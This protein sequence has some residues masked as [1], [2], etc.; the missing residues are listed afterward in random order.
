MDMAPTMN[1]IT[2]AYDHQYINIEDGVIQSI[3]EEAM[4]PLM[5]IN[6]DHPSAVPFIA[7][8]DNDCGNSSN[9]GLS[10]IEPHH[11]DPEEAGAII[12]DY[13]EKYQC[14]F[15]TDHPDVVAP[16]N[17]ESTE[18]LEEE[19]L[20]RCVTSQISTYDLEFGDWEANA[21]DNEFAPFKDYSLCKI[22]QRIGKA[23][24]NKSSTVIGHQ[25]D[26]GDKGGLED[27][28]MPQLPYYEDVNHGV[29]QQ[30]GMDMAPT[31]NNITNAYHHQYI[32]IVDGA[33]TINREEAMPPLMIINQ[34]HP[35]A[36]PFIA[37]DDNDCG[38]S[39]NFGLSNIEPHHADPEE[40]GAI[41]QDY[42]QKYQ[43]DFNTDHPDVVARLTLSRREVLEEE[44]LDRF[45]DFPN[46]NLDLEFGDWEAD[47]WDNEFAPDST[48]Y[49]YADNVGQ[50]LPASLCCGESERP[51]SSGV[52]SK[53]LIVETGLGNWNTLLC[54]M[55]IQHLLVLGILYYVGVKE[56]SSGFKFNCICSL[57]L[58]LLTVFFHLFTASQAHGLLPPWVDGDDGDAE[59]PTRKKEIASPSTSGNKISLTVSPPLSLSLSLS[60][61]LFCSV[62]AGASCRVRAAWGLSLFALF[63]FVFL[64]FALLSR[65]GIVGAR[66][67]GAPVECAWGR[68][69]LGRSRG[70]ALSV[71]C[72]GGGGGGGGGEFS[73]E[74]AGGGVRARSRGGGGGGGSSGEL[75]GGGGEFSGELAQG[76]GL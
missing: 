69:V 54:G 58:S 60:L 49:S 2:N 33:D 32:N 8:D 5:I 61:S 67:R 7:T 41:I 21:W 65:G 40:A 72:R 11:A 74:L 10:N 39:S 68:G 16:P 63:S 52:P 44:G 27:Y 15:N 64:C 23:S 6:Q 4:P 56:V 14:D 22:Y 70:G 24:R 20:D 75:A 31:M 76:G 45:R 34:D 26:V 62:V 13:Q 36:V 17:V 19:G 3:C 28:I 51:Q 50:F 38:N 37:T 46:F 9:F 25:S 30:A 53:V 29:A 18:V 47:A 35:S 71:H 48:L 43:C 55:L 12:Q 66:A 59:E 57:L 42:Q 1:N 73:G